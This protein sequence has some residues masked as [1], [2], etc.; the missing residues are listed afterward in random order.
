[1]TRKWNIVNDQSNAK[2]DVGKDFIYNTEAS[3]SSF[4]DYS[5]AYILVRGDIT[6]TA[7]SETQILFKYYAPF[8][9]CI[10]KTNGTTT[11]HAGDLDLIMPMHNLIEYSS[12]Y[13]ETTGILWF[14]SNDEGS[15]LDVDVANNSNFNSFEY[16][17]KLIGKTVAQDPLNYANGVLKNA[18]IAFRLKYLSNFWRSLE[19]PL[20]SCKVKLKLKCFACNW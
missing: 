5:D 12:N 2:C 10:T 8:T 18:A 1:M 7:S 3:K 13:S 17:A 15:N 20:I 6:V 19:I 14:Y 4:C 11:D 16:K 9:E